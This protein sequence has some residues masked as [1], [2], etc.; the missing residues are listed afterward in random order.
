MKQQQDFTNLLNSA[1]LLTAGIDLQIPVPTKTGPAPTAY[2]IKT[3]LSIIHT[4]SQHLPVTLDNSITV[5]L[6]ER[7]V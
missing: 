6:N 1:Q 3:A 5:L 4:D 7:D 2:A